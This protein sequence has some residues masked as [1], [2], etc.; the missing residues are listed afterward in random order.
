MRTNRVASPVL[1]ISRWVAKMLA[2][3]VPASLHA[4]LS[5][6]PETEGEAL[7][8]FCVNLLMYRR[9]DSLRLWRR[10]PGKRAVIAIW[11]MAPYG[12]RR[13][14]RYP[15]IAP[16]SAFIVFPWRAHGFTAACVPSYPCRQVW[17]LADRCPE[18][19]ADRSHGARAPDD[20]GSGKRSAGPRRGALGWPELI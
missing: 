6:G 7:R 12:N 16:D 13:F 3:P 5:A 20:V 1:W 10:L 2:H 11:L 19:T 8:R 15:C 14:S 4:M 17:R 18:N 9:W